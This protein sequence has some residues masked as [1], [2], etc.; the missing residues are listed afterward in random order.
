MIKRLTTT[1]NMK[2]VDKEYSMKFKE[3]TIMATTMSIQTEIDC[4]CDSCGSLL[5]ATEDRA[6]RLSIEPCVSCMKAERKEG[7]DE[8]YEE[9]ENDAKEA[10]P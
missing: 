5:S 8:G 7:Y 4:V 3:R 10:Q 2:S 6:G 9:G 1:K